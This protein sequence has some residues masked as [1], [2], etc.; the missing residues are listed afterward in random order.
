[1]RDA[2]QLVRVGLRVGAA[3]LAALPLTA[4]AATAAHA[5][6]ATT[7]DEH[8]LGTARDQHPGTTAPDPGQDSFL[9]TDLVAGV[10][11]S[12]DPLDAPDADAARGTDTAAD[13]PA[14]PEAT[15]TDTGAETDTAAADD[16]IDG[17]EDG[18]VGGA[19]AAEVDVDPGVAGPSTTP[20]V[21]TTSSPAGTPR[22][23]SGAHARTGTATTDVRGGGHGPDGA[24]VERPGVD[25]PGTAAPGRA[26]ARDATTAPDSVPTPGSQQ[27]SRGVPDAGAGASS[28]ETSGAGAQDAAEDGASRGGA[29]GMPGANRAEPEPPRGPLTALVDGLVGP[30][31]LLGGD[32]LLA[33]LVGGVFD[34]PL[35]AVDAEVSPQVQVGG[36]LSGGPVTQSTTSTAEH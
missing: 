26:H 4:A 20:G 36:I 35:L 7:A 31:G 21:D 11:A 2:R 25:S 10:L 30:T 3:G 34:G 32:G 13:T 24:P 18:A 19:E 1:M 16:T 12:T 22:A 5:D 6:D 9:A 8:A 15:D 23:E 14:D 29:T 33:G 17:P 27:A 28:T